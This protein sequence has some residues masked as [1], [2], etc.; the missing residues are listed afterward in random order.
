LAGNLGEFAPGDDVVKFGEFLAFPFV[1]CPGAV[2]GNAKITHGLV[3]CSV[4][5]NRVTGEI[6]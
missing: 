1:I 3:G 2:C 5:K 6:T 4:A